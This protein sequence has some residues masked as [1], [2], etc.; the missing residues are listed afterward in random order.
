MSS[1]PCTV[2]HHNSFQTGGVVTIVNERKRPKTPNVG[3]PL[4]RLFPIT[5]LHVCPN[6][7][8][9]G[10]GALRAEATLNRGHPYRQDMNGAH[11]HRNTH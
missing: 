10:W 3:M 8:L 2:P 1:A 4:N 5:E 7:D 6:E 11:S 9:V